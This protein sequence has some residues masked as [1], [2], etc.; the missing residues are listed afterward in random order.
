MPL[1]II[2]ICTIRIEGEIQVRPSLLSQQLVVDKAGLLQRQ[3]AVKGAQLST[4]KTDGEIIRDST[5]ALVENESRNLDNV[6]LLYF[7][8]EPCHL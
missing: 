2:Y 8:D 1:F 4:R 6:G 3:A 7:T 5:L